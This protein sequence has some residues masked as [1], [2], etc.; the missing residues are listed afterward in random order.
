MN[1]TRINPTASF[2]FIFF[3]LAAA[4]SAPSAWPEHETHTYTPMHSE[5][6]YGSRETVSAF[7]PSFTSED[8]AR[9]LTAIYASLLESQE[10]LG[11]EFE[12][13][14]EANIPEMYES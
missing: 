14:W 12:A 8:F 7:D 10:P 4:T 9:E 2:K 13:V 1:E 5:S 6:S 3:S 11:A